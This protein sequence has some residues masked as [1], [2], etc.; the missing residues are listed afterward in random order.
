MS[1]ADSEGTF[2]AERVYQIA[3]AMQLQPEKS[4]NFIQGYDQKRR[5]LKLQ[6]A[7]S[8]KK[9]IEELR[10]KNEKT[11]ALL[12]TFVVWAG[13][14][15]NY[16]GEK[17]GDEEIREY[18]QYLGDNASHYV[19]ASAEFAANH[20]DMIKQIRGLYS[21]LTGLG[22]TVKLYEDDEKVELAVKCMTGGRME[23]EGITKMMKSEGKPYYCYHCNLW[24]EKLA[25]EKGLNMKQ[26]Y[27]LGGLKC[28]FIGYKKKR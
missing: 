26:I 13:E 18:Y 16:I 19:S 28:R 9:E 25:K 4:K 2:S 5:G 11:K 1:L 10:M 7:A 14:S 12:W 21:D 22:S 3:Q 24:Y 27:S 8:L 15:A 20:R 23:R 17:F 6:E